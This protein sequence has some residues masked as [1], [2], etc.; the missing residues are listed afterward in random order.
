MKKMGLILLGCMLLLAGCTPAK[1]ESAI[2][3]AS[4]SAFMEN[5]AKE[6]VDVIWNVDYRTF[7]ADKTTA[8]AK[9]YYDKEF[10]AD[11]LDDIRVNAGTDA[12][13][14]EKLQAK[15]LSV[16]PVGE[17]KE[18]LG[19]T[20]FK[21]YTVKAQVEIAHYEPVYPEESFFEAGKTY[22][23]EYT[24][25]F[26]DQEGELKLSAFGFEPAD[27][28]FL[29]KKANN[30]TLTKSQ[31]E[32]MKEAARRYYETRY[33]FDYRSY[34]SKAVYGY[35]QDNMDAA[36]F[37]REGIT[38][39]YIDDFKKDVQAFKMKSQIIS[40]EFPRTDENKSRFDFI[41]GVQFYYTVQ[42]ELKYR[43]A[44]SPEYFEKSEIKQGEEVY[45][46]ETLGFVFEN[47]KPKLAYAEYR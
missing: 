18:K 17:G 10:L 41:D 5:A 12:V 45:L 9:K 34:D 30:V 8:Y 47:E 13:E 1:A 14:E 4:D 16:S 40:L 25:Y 44:A 2:S 27:G 36:F 28:P 35:Y 3:P 26:R 43:I 33:N 22:T 37:E 39:K 46:N 21:K 38:Q 11:Y 19:D 15:V 20:L 32:A 23:L 29:P 6:L 7:T 31:V 24:L 42:A